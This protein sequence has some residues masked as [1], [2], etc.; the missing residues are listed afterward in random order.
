MACKTEFWKSV[1]SGSSKVDDLSND[2]NYHLAY[3][4]ISFCTDK[5]YLYQ[6]PPSKLENKMGR[7]NGLVDMFWILTKNAEDHIIFVKW[8][9]D[10]FRQETYIRRH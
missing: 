9:I 10:R 2:F 8:K 3:L 5:M 6:V 7:R 4:L 1:A